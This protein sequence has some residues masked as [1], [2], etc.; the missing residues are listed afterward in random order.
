MMRYLV[1]VLDKAAV[2]TGLA[3]LCSGAAWAAESEG[4]T[5]SAPASVAAQ[6]AEPQT[7]TPD[8]GSQTTQNEV[9]PAA[10]GTEPEGEK[11]AESDPAISGPY[12]S[13]VARNPFG[14]RD[15]P[16][17]P[18][19]VEPQ[20]TNQVSPSALKLTGITTMFGGKR[21]MFVVMEPGKPILNSDMVLEG[22]QDPVT[23]VKVLGID[24]RASVVRVDYGGRQLA[25]NF[26]DN[27]YKPPAGAAGA[28]QPGAAGRAGAGGPPQGGA[29]SGASSVTTGVNPSGLQSVPARPSRFSSGGGNTAYGNSAYSSA[30]TTQATTE[31]HALSMRAQEAIARQQGIAFPPSPPVPGVDLTTSSSGTTASDA[32]AAQLPPTPNAYRSRIPMPPSLPIR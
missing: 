5:N 7:E 12:Q 18:P 15:P 6:S 22:E 10:D 24:E 1:T 14:L 29:R 16:P 9:E 19:V 30:Q 28:A 2:W 8:S 26:V 20:P 11:N 3:L 4:P 25:L 27:G 31:Q 32:G 21:A 13:I 17:A 23:N